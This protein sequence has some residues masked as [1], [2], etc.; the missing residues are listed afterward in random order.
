MESYWRV[1]EE[2]K[3]DQMSI[4]DGCPW[5]QLED[6]DMTGAQHMFIRQTA[7]EMTDFLWRSLSVRSQ[8]PTQIFFFFFFVLFQV[9]SDNVMSGF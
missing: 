1:K 3:G 7:E 4:S 2:K 5:Q 8:M 6:E 9:N